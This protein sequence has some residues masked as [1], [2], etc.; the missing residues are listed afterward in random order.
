MLA[1]FILFA[2]ISLHYG[3]MGSAFS[4]GGNPNVT[5]L[6]PNVSVPRTTILYS[7][8]IDLFL[9][10]YNRA[11]NTTHKETLKV[12]SGTTTLNSTDRCIAMGISFDLWGQLPIQNPG[13]TRNG[14]CDA[15]WGEECSKNI[16]ATLMS[17]FGNIENSNCGVPIPDIQSKPPPGCP[18]KNSSSSGIAS[19]VFLRNGSFML[20]EPGPTDPSKAWVYFQSNPSV[21]GDYDKLMKYFVFTYFVGRPYSSGRADATIS[22]M[23]VFNKT[24]GPDGENSTTQLTV[25][26]NILIFVSLFAIF[27]NIGL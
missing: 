9:N 4:F 8:Q 20:G 27:L 5:H 16:L 25:S 6:T 3:Y 7:T 18:A 11:V 1:K 15:L 26:G 22:C 17:S 12:L 10:V 19:I 24:T 14:G 23:S 21:D 13:E 2:F